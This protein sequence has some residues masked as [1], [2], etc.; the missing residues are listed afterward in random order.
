MHF[1]Y[2]QSDGLWVMII[3]DFRVEALYYDYLGIHSDDAELDALLNKVSIQ[4]NS[5]LNEFF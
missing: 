2:L 3:I 1:S 5:F 4:F